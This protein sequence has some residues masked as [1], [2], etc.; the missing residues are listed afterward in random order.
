MLQRYTSNSDKNMFNYSNQ[1]F[2][3][4]YAQARLRPTTLRRPSC[5][6]QCEKI[7]TETAANV[8]TQDLA[9]FVAI[10]KNLDGYQ[11]Y[12]MYVMDMST[13]HYVD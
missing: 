3:K 2:D 6:N 4:V 7:L 10:N 9:E 12:P 8:Y 11:F 5:T 13:I 1:E